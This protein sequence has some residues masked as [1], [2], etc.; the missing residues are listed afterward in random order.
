MV[1]ELLNTV[2]LEHQPLMKRLVSWVIRVP[3]FCPFG[4]K[5][6]LVSSLGWQCSEKTVRFKVVVPVVP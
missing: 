3:K 6:D 5:V 4:I 2:E 1:G